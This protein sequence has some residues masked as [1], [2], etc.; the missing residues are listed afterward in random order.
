MENLTSSTLQEIVDNQQGCAVTIY[1]PLHT[2][3]SPPHITENQ[4]RIKNLLRKAAEQVRARDSN[5]KLAD[6]LEAKAE[7][8]KQDQTLWK[9][10]SPGA[11]LCA[12]D[13]FLKMIRLPIDTEEY[14][15]V[16]EQFHLAP[17]IGLQNDLR[18]FYLLSI[19]QHNPKLYR[20]TMYDLKPST[21]ELPPSMEEA[22]NIDEENKKTEN[23]GTATGSSMNTSWFNGRGG[24]R[25][26]VEHDRLLF[27]R[28]IDNIIW[29]SKARNLPLILAGTESITVDYR[30]MSKHPHLLKNIIPGNHSADDLGSLFAQAQEIIRQE[31]IE[32]EHLSVV[33][34]YQEI[35]GANPSKVAHDIK[36]IDRA[37]AEGRIDKLLTRFIRK[38]ADVAQDTL[39]DRPR[40][41]FPDQIEST[42][43][44]HIAQAVWQTSGKIFSLSSDEMPNGELAVANLRY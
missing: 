16:E 43:L 38:T 7:E 8:L 1:L 26:P 28:A 40:I 6:M 19:A 11:L 36:S 33:Q 41:T 37:A 5:S 29:K 39:S 4:I 9:D 23:Q 34:E 22:F 20:G 2:S 27:F 30:S 35:G 25:N 18:E 3:A 13:N 31:L 17:V 12:S 14:I 24:S 15:A 32:P 21:I 42:R 10:P 44:N